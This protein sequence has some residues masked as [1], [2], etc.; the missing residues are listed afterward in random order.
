[1]ID[2][3]KRIKIVLLLDICAVLFFL[4]GCSMKDSGLYQ[5]SADDSDLYQISADDSGLYQGSEENINSYQTKENN[6]VISGNEDETVE[7]DTT[8][9]VHVCGAVN[10]P[11]VYEFS[12]GERVFDAIEAAGGF[13]EE[14]SQDYLNLA[15]QLSDG[16][17]IVVPTKTEVINMPVESEGLFE[18]NSL[19]GNDNKSGL[20]NINTADK[21]RLCQISGI[22]ETKADAIISYRDN[23]G[24]FKSTE[25]IMNVSGIGS[26]TYDRI[27]DEITVKNE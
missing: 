20:I 25:D 10:N 8:I 2:K 23:Y 27:K 15:K 5:I 6:S 7:S 3:K 21:E 24:Y 11:G 22:G 14:A 13:D 18:D 17:K 12:L 26:G 1:M 4:C 9:Y 16:M 19:S